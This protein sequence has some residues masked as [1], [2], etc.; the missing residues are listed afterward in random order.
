M[1]E[2]PSYVDFVDKGTRL[3]IYPV[4][5]Q[6]FKEF[7]LTRDV[8]GLTGVGNFDHFLVVFTD[9]LSLNCLV[10]SPINWRQQ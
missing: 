8:K 5:L 10:V 3:I 4:Q 9:Y 6:A 2:S 7:V 1:S